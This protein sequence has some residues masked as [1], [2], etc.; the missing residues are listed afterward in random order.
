MYWFKSL[1]SG[2]W[3]KG[4]EQL[5]S[6]IADDKWARHL[7][8]SAYKG[9]LDQKEINEMI[10]GKDFWMNPAEV[11]R[12]LEKRNKVAKKSKKNP[13]VKLKRG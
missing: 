6:V 10:E 2:N 7:F 1:C 11:K 13:K 9:F 12:R 3:G 5:A 4:N 8:E